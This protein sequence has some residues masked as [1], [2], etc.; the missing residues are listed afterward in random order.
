MCVCMYE[1]EKQGKS[2]CLFFVTK[3]WSFSIDHEWE[4]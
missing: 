2:V 1:R 4:D 3:F